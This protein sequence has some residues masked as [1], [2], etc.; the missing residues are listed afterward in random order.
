MRRSSSDEPQPFP[1]LIRIV[2]W[3]SGR[4]T[5]GGSREQPSQERIL[6]S[7]RLVADDGYLAV[8]GRAHQGDDPAALEEAEDALAIRQDMI[9]QIQGALVHPPAEA[10]GAHGLAL[11][12]KAT[13]WCSRQSW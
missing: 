7:H 9:H 11:T 8:A 2:G 13:T 12:E 6:V 5:G 3:T 10:T 1:S 4:H